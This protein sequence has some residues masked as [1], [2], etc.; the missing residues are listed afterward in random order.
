MISGGLTLNDVCLNIV[1]CEHKTAPIDSDGEYFAVG[2]PAMRGHKIDFTEARQISRATFLNW[3]R[4]LAP[5]SGDLLFARE[6]PVGPVVRVP[7]ELN[8]A[9]GQRTVLM[10]PD[11]DMIDSKYLYYL[12]TSPQLQ[13]EVQVKAE[14]STVPHLNVA[15]IRSFELPILPTLAYQRSVGSTLG[16]FDEQIETNQRSMQLAQEL[17]RALF[18]SW[19]VKRVP[20]GGT[21]PKTWRNGKLRDVLTLV[22]KPTKAGLLSDLPYVP[23]D[24]I[25]KSFLGLEHFRPNEDAKS[26]LSLFEKDDILLG[27][28]RVYF[29]R[30]A[31][32]P[33]DGVTRNTTFVLRPQAS[34]YLSF[35]VLLA[36]RDSTIAYAQATS[37]GSTM[38]YAVWDGGLAD[39]PVTIP[40]CSSQ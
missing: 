20:W 21:T 28:M 12:F 33:F 37:K 39:M 14:G 22:K 3:T 7:K 17:L 24:S 4:R 23:V 26:S 18:E 19:F 1:D 36:D 2:T 29:H 40:S 5:Q 30:V 32:A 35:A 15:D 6:A 31:L 8:I 27:A 11:P 25:S 13:A 9:P 10:R 38:P 16:A 34:E